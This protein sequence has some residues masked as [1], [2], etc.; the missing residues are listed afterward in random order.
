[1]ASWISARPVMQSVW[2][3]DTAAAV[4]VYCVGR[5]FEHVCMCV[6]VCVFMYVCT[7]M[8]V[9]MSVKLCMYVCMYVCVCVCVCVYVCMYVYVYTSMFVCPTLNE[10]LYCAPSISL[11]RGASGP[12]QTEKNIFRNWW[13]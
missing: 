4:T 11:G 5:D 10:D 7:C 9:C 12:G 1:M 8:S 2:V 13:N 6:Y 3:Q